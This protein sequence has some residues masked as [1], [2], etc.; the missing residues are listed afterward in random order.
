MNKFKIGD[1]VQFKE[2]PTTDNGESIGYVQPI[3][4][5]KDCIRKEK[6][7]GTDNIIYCPHVRMRTSVDWFCADG[8]R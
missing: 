3:V 2:R 7:N 8:E 4:R 6:V 1:E 5:C